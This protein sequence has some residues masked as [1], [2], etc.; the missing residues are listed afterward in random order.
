MQ[1]GRARLLQALLVLCAIPLVTAACSSSPSDAPADADGG[2]QQPS[3]NDELPPPD[4]GAVSAS[5]VCLADGTVH[6]PN[7]PGCSVPAN[8]CRRQP[9]ALAGDWFKAW[10]KMSCA[11]GDWMTGISADSTRK[12]HGFNCKMSPYTAGAGVSATTTSCR[13]VNYNMA[14]VPF[15][16]GSATGA[17]ADWAGGLPRAECATTEY[18]AGYAEDATAYQGT[19]LCCTFA[20]KTP[21]TNCSAVGFTTTVDDNRESTTTGDWDPGFKKLEC[22]QGR[23]VA[24]MSTAIKAGT[25][26]GT[27]KINA[28]LCCDS[29]PEFT[30]PAPTAANAATCCNATSF[31]PAVAKCLAN[32]DVNG[33]YCN[34][35]DYCC[36]PGVS[37]YAGSS[38]CDV[39]SIVKEDNTDGTSGTKA[40][41]S[42]PAV[43][44]P[45]IAAGAWSYAN[46]KA[47]YRGTSMF[48][49]GYETNLT[50][51]ASKP[52]VEAVVNAKLTGSATLFGIPVTLA[53][54]EANGKLSTQTVNIVVN[55]LGSDLYTYGL[56]GAGYTGGKSYTQ[57]FFSQSKSFTIGPVPVTVAGSVSGTFGYSDTLAFQGGKLSLTAGPSLGANATMSVALGGG[58]KG[59]SLTAGIEG[60]MTL[61]SAA[62]TDTVSMT[63][64]LTGLTYAANGTATATELSGT[65]NLFVRLKALFYKKSYNH[66]LASFTAAQQVIPFLTYSGTQAW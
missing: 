64:T 14:T 33:S 58:V 24:G 50:M 61:F 60:S 46:T 54:I 53:R 27:E 63:P 9:E 41:P 45:T 43:P 51:S 1:G 2:A 16:N 7:P 18:M 62:V 26:G 59:F 42:S 39:T 36:T 35:I 15:P 23:A 11:S 34:L 48:A 37:G 10:K 6:D 3:G 13:T 66:Q 5:T 4:L 25:K 22:G 21:N 57:T 40:S 56:A 28:L 17:A 30:P 8:D 49:G 38:E 65:I 52:P 44:V 19:I 12:N 55:A 32:S 29:A 47:V 31:P 20:G